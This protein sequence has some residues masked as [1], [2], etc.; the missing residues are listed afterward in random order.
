M[1]LEMD[2][3]LGIDWHSIITTEEL[4]EARTKQLNRQEE[5]IEEAHRKLLKTQEASVQYWDRKN[6]CKIT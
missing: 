6:G 4:L 3:Y 2:T 1:D 5:V